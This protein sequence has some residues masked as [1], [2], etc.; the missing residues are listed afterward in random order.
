MSRRSKAWFGLFFVLF[1]LLSCGTPTPD[2]P[3]AKPK[4][5]AYQEDCSCPSGDENRCSNKS[6]KCKC[7]ELPCPPG[8]EPKTIGEFMEI[9]IQE[10]KEK[11]GYVEYPSKLIM[12]SKENPSSTYHGFNGNKIKIYFP[13]LP[14]D[15]K[16]QSITMKASPGQA[17]G[18]RLKRIQVVPL[19]RCVKLH[20]CFHAPGFE[21]ISG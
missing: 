11:D 5:D 1:L 18:Y 13:E 16:K 9:R 17:P 10:A 4:E 20:I 6:C 21:C 14:D 2:S 8:K 19:E 15:L 7:E 3:D 12:L